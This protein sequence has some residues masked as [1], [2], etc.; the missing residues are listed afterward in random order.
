ME[1]CQT[2]A[3]PLS[4]RLLNQL[5]IPPTVDQL[6]RS[7]LWGKLLAEV[8]CAQ[9]ADRDLAVTMPDHK[10]ASVWLGE[11]GAAEAE[12]A[13]AEQ[14]L[15]VRLPPSYRAFLAES[16]GFDNIGPFNDRL[17]NAAEIEWFRVR[18]PDWVFRSAM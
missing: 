1:H 5:D 3:P 12:I 9:V 13:S 7:S 15:G 11:Q 2:R 16:N 17:Y 4:A 18:D 6:G 10:I 8:S 14:R